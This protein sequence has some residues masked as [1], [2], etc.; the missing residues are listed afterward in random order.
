MRETITIRVAPSTRA[1]LRQLADVDGITA[2]EELVRL[3]RAERQRRLGLA[4]AA[5]ETAAAQDLWLDA[6]AATVSEYARG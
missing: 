3:L 6:G 2:D 4:L 5:H 1:A